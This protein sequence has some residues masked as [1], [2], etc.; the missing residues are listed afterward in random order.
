MRWT[1]D[2][3]L[4]IYLS[5]FGADHQALLLHNE[6]RWLSAG[7]CLMKRLFELRIEV[8]VL[9]ELYVKSFENNQMKLKDPSYLQYL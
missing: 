4:K 1:I 5:E 8:V 9:L 7:R 6:N 3:L 2:R